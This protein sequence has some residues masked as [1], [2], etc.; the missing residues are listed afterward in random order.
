MFQNLIIFIQSNNGDLRIMSIDYTVVNHFAYEPF[1]INVIENEKVVRNT[2]KFGITSSISGLELQ[3]DSLKYS[4]LL[5]TFKLSITNHASSVVMFNIIYVK[6]YKYDNSTIAYLL[7]DDQYTSE[8][9]N[10]ELEKLAFIEI[11][12]YPQLSNGLKIK[13]VKSINLASII[14]N[15]FK[16]HNVQHYDYMFK[17]K[18]YNRTLLSLTLMNGLYDEI[19]FNFHTLINL[20]VE[21]MKLIENLVNIIKYDSI[22]PHIIKSVSSITNA[23]IITTGTNSYRIGD[24]L[25]A[26]VFIKYTNPKI[27]QIYE[28]SFTNSEF[29]HF[30]NVINTPIY[31]PERDSNKNKIIN[32]KILNVRGIKM[33]IG[34]SINIHFPATVNRFDNSKLIRMTYAWLKYHKKLLDFYANVDI[35][36]LELL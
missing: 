31:I 3:L 14:S 25:N 29:N 6:K 28:D 24:I 27:K 5:V 10:N 22:K 15:V 18:P 33:I 8:P 7:Y 32:T 26:N 23:S 21:L 4:D 13:G 16:K 17:N 36:K 11:L 20:K 19:V 12:K 34:P 35:L 2:P 9:S 1:I 30:K